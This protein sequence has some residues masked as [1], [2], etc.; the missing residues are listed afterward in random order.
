M[1]G[2]MT[3][4]TG[5]V[6]ASSLPQ[7]Q[8]HA[9]PQQSWVNFD[10]QWLCRSWSN[11]APATTVITPTTHAAMGMAQTAWE[12]D[13]AGG[14]AFGMAPQATTQCTTH[15]RI[16]GSLRL[17]SDDASWTPNPSGAWPL[18][19]D[20]WTV[21]KPVRPVTTAARTLAAVVKHKAAVTQPSHTSGRTG[22]SASGSTGGTGGGSSNGGSSGGSTGG[23]GGY[24]PW[25]PVPGRPTYGMHDFAGDP[26]ASSFGVCT[27]YA[28]Y[29][30][31]SEHLAS[32]GAARNWVAGARGAGLSVGYSPLAGATVVFS[33]G[34]EGAGG[35][36]HVGHVE[37]V[38]GGGW[39][40]I[41]EMNFYWNG[42]GW[43]R[44]DFRYAYVRAGVT[45]IY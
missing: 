44:V 35:T 32:F 33:P 20:I 10:G 9:A 36:G 7:S 23:S 27:W 28:S 13:V 11:S 30:R 42:G 34:V 3:L 26:Y 8:T 2:G 29:R 16:D 22:G 41:S 21:D 17:L 12:F 5:V 38:L 6:N 31:P 24:N 14:R 40:I 18:A 25:S 4:S 45:F 43:G 1:L 15:W 19:D 39:F 37:A